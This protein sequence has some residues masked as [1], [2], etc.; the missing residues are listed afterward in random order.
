MLTDEDKVIWD[1]YTKTVTPLKNVKTTSR[2][3]DLGR[4]LV[5]TFH[6]KRKEKIAIPNTLDLHGFTLEEAYSLFVR[7]LNY[8]FENNTRKIV[9]ITGKGKEGKGLLKNEFPKWLEVEQIKEKIQI[10]KRPLLNDGGAFEL[11]L[12]QR[13]K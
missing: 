10:T 11:I 9:V 2:L 5:G 4:C 13:K 1:A 3:K 12:K 8:H 6:F 7:F